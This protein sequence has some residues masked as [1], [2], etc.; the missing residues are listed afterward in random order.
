MLIPTYFVPG[1]GQGMTIALVAVIHVLLSHGFAIGIVSMIV[2]LEAIGLRRD[3]PALVDFGRHMLKPAVIIITAVGAVTGTGIWFTL[4]AVAPTAIGSL[5]RVFFW[6]WFT[7]WLAFTAEVVILMFYYFLWERMIVSR[8]RG[9]LALGFAYVVVALISATL[10]SGILGFMLTP[11]GWVQD[12][13]LFSGFFNPTFW[14]MVILRIFGGLCLGGVFSLAFV[15]FSRWS[16]SVLRRWIARICGLWILVT[17]VL[18]AL[19]V[20]WYFARVPATYATHKIFS[21]LTSNWAHQPELFTIG[22]VILV[23]IIALGALVALIGRT[24]AA[25]ALVI[26]TLIA[27]VLLVTEYERIREFVRGPYLMPGYM[28]ASQVTLTESFYNR[29]HGMLRQAGWV[30]AQPA[31]LSPRAPAGHALFMANCAMCHSIGGINDIRDRVR[32]RTQ[33]SVGV[34]VR[35]TEQMIPFMPTFAGTDTEALTLAAYLY[36]LVGSRRSIDAVAPISRKGAERE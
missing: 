21:V 25:R 14:P 15:L 22:N 27:S 17:G 10:I 23:A 16:E 11:D 24:G 30:T 18:C 3:D 4:S 1:L 35:N 28:Y 2:F 32:G 33:P 31:D 13:K 7:E 8:P 34:I 20:W 19:A 6:P 36:E 29:D 26:P 9:H 5:L 12:H